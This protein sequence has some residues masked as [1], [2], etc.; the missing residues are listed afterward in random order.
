MQELVPCFKCV[1]VTHTKK[2]PTRIFC[3]WWCS[4]FQRR[5]GT[6]AGWCSPCLWSCS[7][8]S[9]RSPACCSAPLPRYPPD[10]AACRQRGSSFGSPRNEQVHQQAS[11]RELTP[12]PDARRQKGDWETVLLPSRLSEGEGGKKK[13][14]RSLRGCCQVQLASRVQITCSSAA[15]WLA[16]CPIARREG[17]ARKSLR[18]RRSGSSP[19]NEKYRRIS[20]NVV[21]AFVQFLLPGLSRLPCCRVFVHGAHRSLLGFYRERERK[22]HVSK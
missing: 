9:P 3:I 2:G 13:C 20:A 21:I 7:V 1:Q 5:P 12:I 22:N 16:G 14:Q 6:A 17:S 19:V 8:V 10:D 4:C 18:G 11:G 15:H